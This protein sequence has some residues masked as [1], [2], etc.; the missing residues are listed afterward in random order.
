VAE[1]VQSWLD[2][3]LKDSQEFCTSH[4]DGREGRRGQGN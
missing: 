3:T 2:G 1:A 4:M